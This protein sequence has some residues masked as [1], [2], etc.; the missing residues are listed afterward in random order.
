MPSRWGAVALGLLTAVAGARAANAADAHSVMGLAKS[1]AIEE[2]RSGAASPHLLPLLDRLAGAQFDDGALGEAAASRRRALK[3]ALR[4]YGNQSPNTALAMVALARV[5]LLRHRYVEAEPLLIAAMP[6]FEAR[7]GA[8]SP[9][10]AEPLAGLARIA[11]ARGDLPA[12]ES[13]ANRANAIAARHP[14]MASSEPLRALGAVYAAEDRFN[15]SERVLR[16]AIAEDRKSYGA[17]T[18]C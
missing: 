12:G 8:D 6:A 2:S 14:T 18:A 5:E 3:I 15:D 7:Y 13:W 17:P 10:L 16:A 1:V 11:V 9:A 4:T